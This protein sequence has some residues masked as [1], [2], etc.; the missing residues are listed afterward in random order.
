MRHARLAALA[1]AT[2][3]LVACADTSGPSSDSD[4]APLVADDLQQLLTDWI[5]RAPSEVP[6]N[7]A[8]E[9]QPTDPGFGGWASL[10]P[11]IFN[12]P[13]TAVQAAQAHAVTPTPCGV[14]TDQGYYR[15]AV[16]LQSVNISD[17]DAA[18]LAGGPVQVEFATDRSRSGQGAGRYAEEVRLLHWNSVTDVYTTLATD[19]AAQTPLVNGRMEWEL[20]ITSVAGW[21][22][23]DSLI[24][25]QFAVVR[26][27]DTD[28][29]SNI[30]SESFWNSAGAPQVKG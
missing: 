10:L 19:G 14:D 27:I 8:T 16:E 22:Q 3:A 1:A 26:A 18:L 7:G 13:A 5:R 25:G 21:V 12:F 24:V 2:L 20:P 9:V 30:H 17:M 29:G 11:T 23:F 15:W 6:H 28:C 4:Q